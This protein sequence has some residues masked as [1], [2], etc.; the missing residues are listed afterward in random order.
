MKFSSF[1]TESIPFTQHR[2]TKHFHASKFNEHFILL[3][4]LYIYPL[5]AKCFYPMTVL[6]LFH[7]CC[8]QQMRRGFANLLL[9]ITNISST[10]NLKFQANGPIYGNRDI[11]SIHKK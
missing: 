9:N 2:S 1:F 5:K 7:P 10:T 11:L 8:L 3:S 4:E 6:R